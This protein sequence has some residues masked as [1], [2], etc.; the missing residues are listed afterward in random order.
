MADTFK[1]FVIA[2]IDNNDDLEY[3]IYIHSTNLNDFL[4]TFQNLNSGY[5]CFTL[6]TKDYKPNP[7]QTETTEPSR[8]R[9]RE[10]ENEK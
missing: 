5:G 2:S 3:T 7:E 10:N 9:M 4:N 1:N 8:K 6:K